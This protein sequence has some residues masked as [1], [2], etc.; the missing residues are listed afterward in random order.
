[1]ADS[2]DFFIF[3]FLFVQARMGKGVAEEGVTVWVCGRVVTF[4]L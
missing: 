4:C 3:F 2:K 1:M